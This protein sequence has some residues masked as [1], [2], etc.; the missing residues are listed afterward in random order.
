[1]RSMVY[2][3]YS[4]VPVIFTFSGVRSSSGGSSRMLIISRYCFSSIGRAA[5][6]SSLVLN[7]FPAASVIFAASAHKYSR[8]LFMNRVLQSHEKSLPS[9]WRVYTMSRQEKTDVVWRSPPGRRDYEQIEPPYEE[10]AGRVSGPSGV[11]WRILCA[12]GTLA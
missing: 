7:R 10:K 11:A 4:V 2:A 3:G 8:M 12:A 1:M 5:S 9:K 6:N